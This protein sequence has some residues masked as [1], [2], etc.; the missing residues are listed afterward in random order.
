VISVSFRG[1]YESPAANNSSASANSSVGSTVLHAAGA[2]KAPPPTQEQLDELTA[3]I[4]FID[5]QLRGEAPLTESPPRANRSI[6]SPEQW[7]T[8]QGHQSDEVPRMMMPTGTVA[9]AST[10]TP[11]SP[12]A[13]QQSRASQRLPYDYLSAQERRVLEQYKREQAWLEHRAEAAPP[14]DPFSVLD[15]CAAS[16]SAAAGSSSSSTP[17][18]LDATKLDESVPSTITEETSLRDDS[19]H[20]DVDA[21]GSL[22]TSRADDDRDAAG[23]SFERK[24]DGP[25]ALYSPSKP[26][27]R[28]HVTAFEPTRAN[29][30]AAGA[31]LQVDMALAQLPSLP[32]ADDTAAATASASL[33]SLMRVSDLAY[34]DLL[35]Q[36]YNNS[37]SAARSLQPWRTPQHI[38]NPLAPPQPA[39]MPTAAEWME[40]RQRERQDEREQREL[41]TRDDALHASMRQRLHDG[42]AR[43]LDPA[44]SIGAVEGSFFASSG[45]GPKK[46]SNG[47]LLESLWAAEADFERMLAE[48]LP[49]VRLPQHRNSRQQPQRAAPSPAPAPTS[50]VAAV[51][52]HSSPAQSPKS[53]RALSQTVTAVGSPRQHDQAATSVAAAAPPRSPLTRSQRVGFAAGNLAASPRRS[54]QRQQQQEEQVAYRPGA[55]LQPRDEVKVAFLDVPLPQANNARRPDIGGRQLQRALEEAQSSSAAAN[56][57]LQVA[58]WDANHLADEDGAAVDAEELKFYAGSGGGG[59]GDVLLAVEDFVMP[60]ALAEL[61][62]VDV[63]PVSGRLARFQPQQ[64]QSQAPDC[65]G[66]LVPMRITQIL[67]QVEREGRAA[68]LVQQQS[69]SQ[70]PSSS[71]RLAHSHLHAGPD[72]AT[73]QRHI[74]MRRAKESMREMDE[75]LE[76]R[77]KQKHNKRTG[78]RTEISRLCWVLSNSCGVCYCSPFFV[79]LFLCARAAIDSARRRFVCRISVRFACHHRV[80][81][82]HGQTKGG[83]PQHTE[84]HGSVL[85]LC[86]LFDHCSSELHLY[87]PCVCVRVGFAFDQ[88]ESCAAVATATACQCRSCPQHVARDR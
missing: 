23:R 60:A 38:P 66:R 83:E 34:P 55:L 84:T 1:D 25:V 20:T 42:F 85:L 29:Q 22:N 64:H 86:G 6:A 79:V 51:R 87:S 82:T 37:S 67:N 10:S 12:M 26:T 53:A 80:R 9:A 14:S 74:A 11:T 44:A 30:I 52:P 3:Q 40:Q 2:G 33:S 13:A 58:S 31:P 88:A 75:E 77:E 16:S 76:V 21:H 15:A 5:R 35:L 46:D 36:G 19:R 47:S 69:Q 18:K 24:Q 57:F 50:A 61:L 4:E 17:Y 49:E 45:R 27:Q 72:P 59:G 8:E 68:G 78:E 62:D 48:E 32:A 28:E 39:A 43:I 7:Q 54:P 56:Q 41:D 70:S 63:D 65:F 81:T 71:P 73:L